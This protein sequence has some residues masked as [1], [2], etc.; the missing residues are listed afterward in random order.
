LGN[1]TNLAHRRNSN[2]VWGRGKLMKEKKKKKK[3][4]TF[5]T[6]KTKSIRGK[7]GNN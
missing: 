5:G 7:R 6:M 1:Q 3:K 2:F 4:N